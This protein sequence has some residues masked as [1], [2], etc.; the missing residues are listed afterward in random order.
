MIKIKNYDKKKQK[1]SL[2]TDMDTSLANAIRRSVLEIPIMAIDEVE[3]IKN[4]S[5]FYDEILAHR[6]GLIPIKTEKGNR[7]IKFRL[8]EV[9]PKMV[10]STNIKPDI[11]ID[12][13]IPV[14][15][16]EKDQEIEMICEA[17]MG[18]G[19][20]H[21][22]YSPGLSYFKHNLDDNVLDFVTIDSEGKVKYDEEELNKIGSEDIIKKISSLKE[23]KELEFTIESWGQLD[24]KDIFIKAIEALEDNLKELGKAVK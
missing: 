2:I 24:A 4:D 21:A 11:G 3:I 14:V 19:I 7:E 8:K 1:L 18:K 20:D 5:A 13:K 10:Y 15:L 23:V 17:R 16:L 22:K 9:G 6:L 12:F